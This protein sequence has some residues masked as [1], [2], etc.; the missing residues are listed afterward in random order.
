MCECVID[1]TPPERKKA[2]YSIVLALVDLSSDSLFS[3]KWSE[4]V[5]MQKQQCA[6]SITNHLPE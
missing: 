4:F 1:R 2:T 5:L 3:D 6:L